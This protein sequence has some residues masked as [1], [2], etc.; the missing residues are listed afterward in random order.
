MSKKYYARART[1][2]KNKKNRLAGHTN[3]SIRRD[4]VAMFFHVDLLLATL[5]GPGAMALVLPP[6]APP[7]LAAFEGLREKVDGFEVFKEETREKQALLA[8]KVERPTKAQAE[9]RAA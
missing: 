2:K 1:L 7:L 3:R 5:A 4:N 8:A 6:A 9:R